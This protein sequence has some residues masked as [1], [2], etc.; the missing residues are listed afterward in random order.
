M[1]EKKSKSV[2]VVGAGGSHSTASEQAAISKSL[3]CSET[4]QDLEDATEDVSKYLTPQPVY[5]YKAP[6]PV[7]YKTT[8][9]K[10]KHAKTHRR[11]P[12]SPMHG[13]LNNAI[14]LPNGKLMK[15]KHAI[16]A[17]IVK[18]K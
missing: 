9:G 17:G 14:R 10:I 8:R 15:M 4:P 13:V 16:K 1:S 7:S 11:S 6:Q 12:V 18:I 5:Q 2:L 3:D